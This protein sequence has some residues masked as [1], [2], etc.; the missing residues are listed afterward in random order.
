MAGTVG[1]R[2][3]GKVHGPWAVVDAVVDAVDIR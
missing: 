1:L 3:G 2:L